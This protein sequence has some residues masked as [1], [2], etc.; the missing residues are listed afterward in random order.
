MVF[1][2]LFVVNRSGGLIHHRH[3]SNKAPKIGTNEWLRIG[4]TFHSL[5]AIAAEASPVRLPGGKNS[6]DGIEEMVT[7]GMVL[8]SFQTR[9]GI[10]FVLT[11]EPQTPDL[12]QVLKEIY[13][14]YTECVLKD[15][16]YELEMPIRSELFVHAVDAL[17]ERVQN[18]V[19][20]SPTKHR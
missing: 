20:I 15:P 8:R 6:N 11:A 9:T 1:L 5:H 10:K 2:H 19:S 16:F 3:L 4:S 13:V 17:V 12:G 18:A 7:G 14:L